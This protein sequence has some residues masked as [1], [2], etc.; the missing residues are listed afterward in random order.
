MDVNPGVSRK[1]T[2]LEHVQLHGRLKIFVNAL[3]DSNAVRIKFIQLNSRIIG[4]D[5][6]VDFY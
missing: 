2:N 5:L 3:I 4:V 1:L 6:R